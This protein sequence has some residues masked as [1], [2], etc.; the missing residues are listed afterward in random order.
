MRK[1]ILF[2]INFIHR[3]SGANIIEI[4][5]VYS[6]IKQSDWML[7]ISHVM[8]LKLSESEFSFHTF[9]MR[10]ATTGAKPDSNS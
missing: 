8:S 3:V 6:E 7:S 5:I 10:L 2:S 9:L 1:K 4:E